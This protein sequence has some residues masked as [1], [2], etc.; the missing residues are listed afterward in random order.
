MFWKKEYRHKCNHIILKGDKKDNN[1][2]LSP[3]SSGYCYKHKRDLTNK[4]IINKNHKGFIK[5]LLLANIGFICI[6]SII[7]YFITKKYIPVKRIYVIKKEIKPIEIKDIANSIGFHKDLKGIKP[8]FK[9]IKY[10]PK[11]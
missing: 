7:V 5:Y 2:T 8:N 1:C 11:I 3:D 6:T 4:N 9:F 10:L